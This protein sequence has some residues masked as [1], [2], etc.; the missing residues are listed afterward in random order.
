[1]SEVMG[2]KADPLQKFLALFLLLDVK[3]EKY[4]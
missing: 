4:L 2:V 1:V 3:K